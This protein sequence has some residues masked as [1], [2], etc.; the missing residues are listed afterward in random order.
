MESLL[1]SGGGRRPGP[2]LAPIRIAR[3][4]VADTVLK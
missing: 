4:L 1:D 3:K 2:D